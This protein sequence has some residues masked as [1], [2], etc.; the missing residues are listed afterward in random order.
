MARVEPILL[1]ALGRYRDA[2]EA[3]FGQELLVVA[4]F[5]SQVT[6]TARPE[7]DLDVL[8]IIRGLPRRRLDRRRLVDPVAH[9][10]SDAFAER[11]STILLTPE[12]AGSVKPFY[13]GMLEGH[14]ALLDR[15][16]FLAGV[17]SRLRERLRALNARQ[18]RDEYGNVYWDLKPDYVLGENVVL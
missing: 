12:E 5:G 15:G 7:S 8:L 17:L 3:R 1:S 4:A 10:V 16:G 2:L 14:L 18:L 6:G 9:D 11:A 13:L